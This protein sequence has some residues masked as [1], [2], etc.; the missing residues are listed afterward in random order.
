M[1]N[2]KLKLDNVSYDL[3]LTDSKKVTA[4][5]IKKSMKDL[6]SCTTVHINLPSAV[7]IPKENT[8]QEIKSTKVPKEVSINARPVRYKSKMNS[9]VQNDKN[10][11]NIKETW[12]SFN[13]K[14]ERK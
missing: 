11:T 3:I 7:E 13:K 2:Y 5:N 8:N 10:V 4:S 14:G 12:N 6:S 9:K 1:Q